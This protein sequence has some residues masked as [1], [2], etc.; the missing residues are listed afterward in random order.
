MIIFNDKCG[1]DIVSVEV[2]LKSKAIT[3]IISTHIRENLMFDALIC[4]LKI[5]VRD[6]ESR[7][8]QFGE[9]F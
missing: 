7:S 9:I 1:V 5:C 6:S 4:M 3:L 8:A 2:L